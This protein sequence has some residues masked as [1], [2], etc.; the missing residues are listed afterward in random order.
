MIAVLSRK[1]S[2]SLSCMVVTNACFEVVRVCVL[3]VSECIQPLNVRGT[4]V[5]NVR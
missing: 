2:I 5:A 1:H 3:L 4:S